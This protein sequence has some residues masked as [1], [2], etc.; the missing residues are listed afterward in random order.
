MRR[1]TGSQNKNQTALQKRSAGIRNSKRNNSSNKRSLGNPGAK[2]RVIGV[3]DIGPHGHLKKLRYKRTCPKGPTDSSRG[4]AEDTT[5]GHGD[6]KRRA[7]GD[8]GSKQR[9]G[10]P[11]GHTRATPPPRKTK[12]RT[13]APTQNPSTRTLAATGTRPVTTD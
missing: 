9:H 11:R 5:Q 8:K 7:V 4:N 6:I 2:A 1:E 10:T 3:P 12:G 13:R